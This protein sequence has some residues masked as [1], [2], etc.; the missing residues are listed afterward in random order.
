MKY[1]DGVAKLWVH[2]NTNGG[3]N[4]SYNVSSVTDHGTGDITVTINVD[5]SSSNYVIQGTNGNQN[6]NWGMPKPVSRF[7]QRKRPE[8]YGDAF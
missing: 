5:F 6:S 8:R 3:I 7:F 4:D 1:H 2:A